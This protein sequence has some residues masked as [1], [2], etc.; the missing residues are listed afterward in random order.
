MRTPQQRRHCRY[1]SH[2][3]KGQK[4]LV[5]IAVSSLK[6]GG[7]GAGAGPGGGGGGLFLL[8][9]HIFWNATTFIVRAR[10]D[11]VKEDANFLR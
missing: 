10:D 11:N 5:G 3:C 4:C 8:Y 1:I 9:K 7:L 6:G 2:Q